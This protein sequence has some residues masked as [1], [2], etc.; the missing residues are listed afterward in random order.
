MFV[1]ALQFAISHEHRDAAVLPYSRFIYHRKLRQRSA[2]PETQSLSWNPYVH[3]RSHKI[4]PAVHI[5]VRIEMAVV[6]TTAVV[7]D[8]TPCSLVASY[9]VPDEPAAAAQYTDWE[10]TDMASK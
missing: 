8:G 10:T 4:L 7:W 3:Y 2:N 6:V 5:R 9:S 1:A